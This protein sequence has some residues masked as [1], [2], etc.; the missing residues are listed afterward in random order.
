MIRERP[1]RGLLVAD[2]LGNTVDTMTPLYTTIYNYS[3]RGV[4]PNL[5]SYSTTS[6]TRRSHR[7]QCG[8]QHGGVCGP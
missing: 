7:L 1:T 6:T 5:L 3:P 4:T 2:V 8:E